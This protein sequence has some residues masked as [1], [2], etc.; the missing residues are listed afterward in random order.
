MI[1]INLL[2]AEREAR[3]KKA[4]AFGTAGQKL[5]VGCSLILVARRRCSSAGATGRSARESTQ[6]DAEI[7]GG[8]AGDARGCTR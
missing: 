6:L 3:K 2:A 5:T 7:A 1:R 4:V 8:A